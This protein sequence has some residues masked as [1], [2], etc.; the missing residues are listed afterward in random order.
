MKQYY[1]YIMANRTNAVLYAGV[2]NDLKR[3]VCEHKQ[4]LIEG[5]TK[6]Y[7]V[8]KLVYYEAFNTI[9][10]AIKREKQI[11]RWRREW[12]IKLIEKRNPR[13]EDLSGLDDL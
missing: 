1:V 9:E 2:T 10:D 13:W 12:K 6:K 7:N 3:R 4:K 5:F 8:V 11:K